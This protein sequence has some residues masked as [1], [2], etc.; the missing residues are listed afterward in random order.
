[1]VVEIILGIIM[2]PILIV[3]VIRA[4]SIVDSVGMLL[5]L[6]LSLAFYQP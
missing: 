2:I 1:M 4:D 3:F 5:W 6:A